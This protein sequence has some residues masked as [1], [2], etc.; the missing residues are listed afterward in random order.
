VSSSQAVV[1]AVIGLG[2]ITPGERVRWDV[3]RN[4]A[5]GWLLTPTVAA[6]IS[7]VGMFV[8]QNVFNLP[9]RP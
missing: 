9:V 2:L 4:I 8:L 6:V 7:V 3:V 5:V 1:G